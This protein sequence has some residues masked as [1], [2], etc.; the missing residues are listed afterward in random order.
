GEVEEG[1]SGVVRLQRL[2][3]HVA[4]LC[5]MPLDDRVHEVVLG[6]KA[7]EDRSVAN[8]GK[9]RDLVDARVGA[10]R[11]EHLR[12]RIEHPLEISPRVGAQLGHQL[13]NTGWSSVRASA[14]MRA[15]S[16][17]RSSAT[18]TMRLRVTRTAAPPKAHCQPCTMEGS[19][20]GLNGSA[21]AASLVGLTATVVRIANP[22]APPTS[23]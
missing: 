14:S 20:D 3:G 16:R 10:R 17:L 23:C 12:R 4:E 2:L 7:P 6:G 22:S 1:C 9:A 21:T 11:G 18:K 13:A 15:T 19:D 5:D 8:P